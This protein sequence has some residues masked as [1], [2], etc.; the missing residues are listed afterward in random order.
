MKNFLANKWLWG[1]MLVAAFAQAQ[2]QISLTVTNSNL[3]LVRENRQIS[4]QKGVQTF[5]LSDIPKQIIPT[6]VLIEQ[7]KNGFNVLEQNYEYDLINAD[8]VL[9]KS[10]NQTIWLQDPDYGLI[11]G[12]LLSNSGG[13]LML[14]DKDGRLQIIPKNDKQK[15]ILEGYGQKS[16]QFITRPALLWK[17]QTRKSGKHDFTLSYLTHGLRWQAD[18]VGK[19]DANDTHLKLACWVTVNNASGKVYRNARLKLMAGDLHRAS[20]PFSRFGEANAI[21]TKAPPRFEEKGFFEYH[22]YTLNGTTTLKDNQVKQIRLFA[23]TPVSVKKKFQVTSRNPKQVQVKIEFKNTRQNHLGIPLPA[24]T[25]RLYKDDGKEMEF[26]G[27]DRISHT[28]KDETVRLTIG[29]AFDIVSERNLIKSERIGKSANKQTIEYKIRN[30]KKQAVTVE[31]L[32]YVPVYREVELL[33]SDSK[34][35]EVRANYFKFKV[36]VGADKEATLNMTYLLK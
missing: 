23:E 29:N 12:T 18:Y 34:P 1:L 5:L 6:S 9:E 33:S 8:K 19:L 25:V 20:R 4:L 35:I 36:Q 31:I 2:N 15:I 10:L 28:P 24:G 14:L 30:H 27:E 3:G 22:L 26:V 32:E 16:E 21:M 11:K 7:G 17:V 13:S